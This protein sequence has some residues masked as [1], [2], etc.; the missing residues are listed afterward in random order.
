[1]RLGVLVSSLVVALMP[2]LAD[3]I[4]ANAEIAVS[5]SNLYPA[6]TDGS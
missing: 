6:N 2:T 1:M 4:I 3:A 5:C